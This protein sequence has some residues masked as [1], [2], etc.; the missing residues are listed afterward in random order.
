MGGAGAELM[1]AMRPAQR[2]RAEFAEGTPGAG[3]HQQALRLLGRDGILRVAQGTS[4]IT[5]DPGLWLATYGGTTDR[6][7]SNEVKA[8]QAQTLLPVPPTQKIASG[9]VGVAYLRN[10]TRDP[11]YQLK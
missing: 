4:K 10:L 2:L 9:T 6:E 11:A 7:P 8:R 3:S 1:R 5:F